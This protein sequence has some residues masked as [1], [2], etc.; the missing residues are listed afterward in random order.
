MP[1]VLS[2]KDAMAL[3]AQ[4]E[5]LRA[6]L[7]GDPELGVADVGFSL[8]GR[9]AVCRIGPWCLA[10]AAEQLVEGVARAGRARVVRQM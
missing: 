4:A 10:A 6:R 2:G 5:R 9:S 7:A 1:W 8:A 3:R